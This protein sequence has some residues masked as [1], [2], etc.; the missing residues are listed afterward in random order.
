MIEPYCINPSMLYHA[1][2]KTW[3]WEGCRKDMRQQPPNGERLPVQ[4]AWSRRRTSLLGQP[5]QGLSA[6]STALPMRCYQSQQGFSGSQ[7]RRGNRDLPKDRPVTIRL[8]RIA[9]PLS[10][11][12]ILLTALFLGLF[13]PQHL[14]LAANN[15]ITIHITRAVSRA[16]VI[17]SPFDPLTLLIERTS[18]PQVMPL[19][20]EAV[21]RPS[22]Q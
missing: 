15:T 2:R 11:G 16:V 22:G 4:V 17:V 12:I 14:A 21:G 5:Q 10:A 1:K 3:N 7:G 8:G 13:F 20:V 19:W 9:S 6:T 18:S